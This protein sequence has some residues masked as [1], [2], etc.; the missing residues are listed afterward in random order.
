M[1]GGRDG[2]ALTHILQVTVFD[3]MLIKNSMMSCTRKVMKES[4]ILSKA[5]LK[6]YSMTV[7]CLRNFKITNKHKHNFYAYLDAIMTSIELL[8]LGVPKS[9]A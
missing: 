2:G 8:R 9:N 6:A 3:T 1:Q 4:L 5:V 7:Y